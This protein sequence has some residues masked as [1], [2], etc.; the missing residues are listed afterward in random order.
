MQDEK[1]NSDMKRALRGAFAANNVLDFDDELDKQILGLKDRIRQDG[2]AS[3]M[4]LFSQYQIDFFTKVAFGQESQFLAENRSTADWSF[5]PRLKHWHIFQGM[6]RVEMLLY[7]SWFT[8]L[9]R[10]QRASSEWMKYALHSIK[11][12]AADGDHGIEKEN[13]RKDLLEK[14]LRAR[15]TNP[16]L[17]DDESLLRMVGSTV[18]AGFDSTP[19]TMNSIIFFLCKNP[20]A[21]WKLKQ[22]VFQ[23]HNQGVLSEVPRW[24]EVNKLPYLDAVIKE[25][26]RLYP[27]LNL[28]LER[29]VPTDG[30]E[31]NGF[32][33]PAGTTVGCH[34]TLI[35]RD[36][37]CYGD[38]ADDFRPER[39]F[40][41]NHVAMERNSLVFGSGK[42]MCIGLHIAELEIKKTIPVIIRDFD[43]SDVFVAYAWRTIC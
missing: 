42:R 5:M 10:K 14:Y 8:V 17:F 38:D 25:S 11:S 24:R 19:F 16:H 2:T 36:T 6:P 41:S 1:L 28:P 12:R 3:I 35:G 32:H 4:E 37:A 40:E 7:Q 30:T 20:E 23:A 15:R 22:E 27:F 31:L 33:V 39:W 29:E 34:S 18:S 9:W 21:Y 26:M 13:A 43:V